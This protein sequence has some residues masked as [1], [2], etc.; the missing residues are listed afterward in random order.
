MG[1]IPLRDIDPDIFRKGPHAP[2]GAVV[3]DLVGLES[4]VQMAQER[5]GL[6]RPHV[7]LPRPAD[8]SY[9]IRLLGT[10]P[11]I[12][13]RRQ[14]VAPQR[15]R[16]APRTSTPPQCW[17][18]DQV[19]TPE[20]LALIPCWRERDAGHEAVRQVGLSETSGRHDGALWWWTGEAWMPSA[21]P[22]QHLR[23]AHLRRPIPTS[24]RA[25]WRVPTPG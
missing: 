8:A 24:A 15:R 18:S 22:L 5:P 25:W 19:L 11:P 17:W 10:S 23:H 14:M 16:H 9:A 7:D 21:L 12:D 6:T 13:E 2:G 4:R 3:P 1:I 20:S